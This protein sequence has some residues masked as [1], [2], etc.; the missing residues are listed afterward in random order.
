MTKIT[1]I[2]GKQSFHE[3]SITPI[4]EMGDIFNTLLD[5]IPDKI[6]NVVLN[7]KFTDDGSLTYSVK[8]KV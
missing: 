5:E 2:K 1:I 6:K 8:Y 4:H 7:I 3:K